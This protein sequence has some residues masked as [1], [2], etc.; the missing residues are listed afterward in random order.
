MNR[1]LAPT[2]VIALLMAIGCTGGEAK[3]APRA[4][5]RAPEHRLRDPT[6]APV[7]PVEAELL[8]ERLAQPA[9]RR[10]SRR[11]VSNNKGDSRAATASH[12]RH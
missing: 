12:R 6:A 2:L 11:V 4:I 3:A 1:I 5:S 9:E 7:R 10:G 8:V